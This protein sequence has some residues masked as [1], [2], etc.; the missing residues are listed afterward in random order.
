M[1]LVSTTR[2]SNHKQ[3][4]CD[5]AVFDPH[6]MEITLCDST[7]KV[8]SFKYDF[9]ECGHP[10][11]LPFNAC[12][13]VFMVKLTQIDIHICAIV[14]LSDEDIDNFSDFIGELGEIEFDV[15]MNVDEKNL[16]LR[17][18]ALHLLAPVGNK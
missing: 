11:N 7:E 6:L 2:D 4:I 15:K 3:L 10:L 18:C 14:E 12:S 1:K 13:A 17:F 8:I 16:F 5:D 9:L